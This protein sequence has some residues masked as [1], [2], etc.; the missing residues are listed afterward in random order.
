[1]VH[2]HRAANGRPAPASGPCNLT[3]RDD[4]PKES[5]LDGTYKLPPVRKAQ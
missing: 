5:V 4:W 3:V 2:D 1:V